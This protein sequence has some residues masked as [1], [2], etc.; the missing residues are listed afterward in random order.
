MEDALRILPGI[1]AAALPL[2]AGPVLPLKASELPPLALIEP[3]LELSMYGTLA[4]AIITR[5]AG[6]GPVLAKL[7]LL[8]EPL[9]LPL[10]PVGT[11]VAEG[12]PPAGT[13][14]GVSAGRRSLVVG[15][16][17]TV[18]SVSGDSSAGSA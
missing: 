18:F 9:T 15:G 4:A 8:L 14:V 1:L 7:A 12:T 3:P 5:L 11:L 16:M 10:P 13:R 6:T 2:A 17:S